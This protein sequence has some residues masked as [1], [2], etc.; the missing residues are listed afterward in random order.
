MGAIY[1]L[2]KIKSGGSNANEQVV[3]KDISMV[4]P[5][6]SCNLDMGSK[7]DV[8]SST[9]SSKYYSSPS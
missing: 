6:F 8:S 1:L 4:S 5:H 3:G 7:I 9:T 2:S